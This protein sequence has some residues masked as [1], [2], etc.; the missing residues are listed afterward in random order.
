MV[1][2]KEREI[3]EMRKELNH[4]IMFNL[5]DAYISIANRQATVSMS[6]LVQFLGM[7]EPTSVLEK[8]VKWNNHGSSLK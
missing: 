2:E 8:L 7:K 6:C 5:K 1:S 4:E 3:E